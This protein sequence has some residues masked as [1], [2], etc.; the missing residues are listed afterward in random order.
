MVFTA[1]LI[2]IHK[3]AQFMVMHDLFPPCPIQT[4][5]RVLG[6]LS[7]RRASNQ[8]CTHIIN[9]TTNSAQHAKLETEHRHGQ[10]RKNAGTHKI[11]RTVEFSSIQLWFWIL[12][13]L[14][15]KYRPHLFPLPF[16]GIFRSTRGP[17]VTSNIKR[18]PERSAQRQQ[19]GE[20]HF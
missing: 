18:Q 17:F 15:S 6:G 11:S 7:T 2:F 14:P 20:I 3:V 13:P 4:T 1:N 19:R 16:P 12:G 8:K 10:K 5:S 9:N